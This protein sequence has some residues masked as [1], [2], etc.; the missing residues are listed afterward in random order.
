MTFLEKKQFLIVVAYVFQPHP[1]FCYLPVSIE[2]DS[3]KVSFVSSTVM[4]M[5]SPILPC[6]EK[7]ET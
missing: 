1:V 2:I 4:M 6:T 7:L 3:R 5:K